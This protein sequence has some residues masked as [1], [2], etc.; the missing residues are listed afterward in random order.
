[1]VPIQGLAPARQWSPVSAAYIRAMSAGARYCTTRRK[2]AHGTGIERKLR[3]P[4]HP[5]TVRQVVI[6]EVIQKRDVAVFPLHPFS[7]AVASLAGDSGVDVRTGG[8]LVRCRRCGRKL[9]ARYTGSKHNIPR[10]SCWREPWTMA[11]RAASLSADCPSMMRLK[12]RF[13]VS[14]SRERLL[15]LPKPRRTTPRSGGCQ[16]RCR[17]GLPAI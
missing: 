14:W 1:M 3:Y 5:W 4:W 8:Q 11:S 12:K 2:N 6:H 17:P 13:C 10:Y 16:L 9:T 15:W 7:T